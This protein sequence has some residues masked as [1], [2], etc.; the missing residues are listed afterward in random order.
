MRCIKC[1]GTL[2]PILPPSVYDLGW[3]FPKV[4][5]SGTN[6][7]GPLMRWPEEG[8]QIMFMREV[9][10]EDGSSGCVVLPLVYPMME[11]PSL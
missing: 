6:A 7:E 5:R 10:N 4:W 11:G 3:S 2:A 9:G 8:V 1:G